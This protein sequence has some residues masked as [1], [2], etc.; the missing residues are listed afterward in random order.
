LTGIRFPAPVHDVVDVFTA[1]AGK[2]RNRRVILGGASAGAC[3][4]AAAALH[5]HRTRGREPDGLMLAY[6]TFHAE[7]PPLSKDLRERIGGRHLFTQFRPSTVHRMNLNYVASFEAMRNPLAFPGGHDLSGLPPTL[8]L[9]ADRD[10]LRASGGAFHRELA[11]AGVPVEYT[12]LPGTTHGF[13]NRPQTAGFDAAISTVV[14]WL[15]L[16]R[17]S[18]NPHIHEEGA[19]P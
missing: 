19:R 12:V 7:L 9:D 1:I 15:D 6:G 4:S 17:A 18:E 5:Q 10:S 2:I 3:L 14:D 13:L 11:A 16:T 8:M